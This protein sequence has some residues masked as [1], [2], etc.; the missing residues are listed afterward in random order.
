M[1]WNKLGVAML[2]GS[3]L[4]GRNRR[5]LHQRDAAPGVCVA[6]RPA[7]LTARNAEGRAD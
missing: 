4:A 2:F 1:D 7:R 3:W 6:S 5:M